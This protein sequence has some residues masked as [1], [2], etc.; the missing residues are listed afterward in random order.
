LAP[1][2]EA[3]AEAAAAAAA[4]ERDGLRDTAGAGVPVGTTFWSQAIAVM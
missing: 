4:G 3:A 1:A 2:A